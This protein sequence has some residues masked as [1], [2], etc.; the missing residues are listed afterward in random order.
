MIISS[1][2]LLPIY[3]PHA[4]A[5]DIGIAIKPILLRD[6]VLELDLVEIVTN[7]SNDFNILVNVLYFLYFFLDLL[8]LSLKYVIIP[9]KMLIELLKLLKS[10][11]FFL[12]VDLNHYFLMVPRDTIYHNFGPFI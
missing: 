6:N 4:V 11:I 8:F 5:V 1:I 10:F 7:V 2:T 3:N 12:V 9:L